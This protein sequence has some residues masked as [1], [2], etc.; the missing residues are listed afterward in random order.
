MTDLIFLKSHFSKTYQSIILLPLCVRFRL[1]HVEKTDDLKLSAEGLFRS[2]DPFFEGAYY[3]L[4]GQKAIVCLHLE[5]LG[6]K[7]KSRQSDTSEK[8]LSLQEI[9]QRLIKNCYI[10]LPIIIEEQLQNIRK[11]MK[12][13]LC[14]TMP[15]VTIQQQQVKELDK[16]QIAEP[17]FDFVKEAAK[18]GKELKSV[19]EKFL[20]DAK[21][22][23]IPV[24]LITCETRIANDQL[25]VV[26]DKGRILADDILAYHKEM[27]VDLRIVL[28]CQT[29]EGNLIYS[30]A[31]VP[32]YVDCKN[33]YLCR[34]AKSLTSADQV[35][36]T[37]SKPPI[38]R[39]FDN[40][41]FNFFKI[42]PC[43]F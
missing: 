29:A 7:F 31:T 22:V 24:V 18:S 16:S 21:N 38:N 27:H 12:R 37:L 9:H 26:L 28:N 39:S 41:Y 5:K 32:N 42:F 33:V 25:V 34:N 1:H 40:M 6:I 36:K 2:T 14:V 23:R 20:T 13:I 35:G 3:K 4:Y 30:N 11:D 43:Q 17:G 19:I 10:N 8:R 15:M